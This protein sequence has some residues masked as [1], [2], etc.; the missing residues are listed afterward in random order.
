M[1]SHTEWYPP[2]QVC[3]P[4]ELPPY[5]RDVYVLKPIV[6]LPTDA[7]LI[8]IHDVIQAASKLSAVPGMHDS[9]LYMQ[10][11]DHLFGAQMARYRSRYSL[12]V[13]PSNATYTPPT[14]TLP[15]HICVTLE[16]VCG[17]PSDE[18]IVK[19]QEALRSYEQVS[20]IPTLYDAHVNM[21]LSQH[22]FDLQMGKYMRRA[23]ESPPS[24][25][26]PV[27]ARPENPAA[28]AEQRCQ[29]TEEMA[30]ATNNMGSGANAP[31][32]LVPQ[33]ASDI[34]HEVMERSN[35]ISE[36]LAALLE[37]S[38]ELAEKSTLSTEQAG[39]ITDRFNQVLERLTRL[40][41]STRPATST[42]D[43]HVERFTQLLERIDRMVEL[44]E[45]SAQQT[46]QHA[47]RL[48][49]LVGQLGLPLEQSG[50]LTG[51][52]NQLFE[53]SNQPLPGFNQSSSLQ[54][55]SRLNQLME[56]QNQ[57]L[58]R[59]NELSEQANESAEE[60]NCLTRRSNLL[61]EQVGKPIERLEGVMKNINKVLVGIQH[62]IIRS[63]KGNTKHAVDCLVNDKGETFASSETTYRK[64]FELISG[65]RT[66]RYEHHVMIGGTVQN[67]PFPDDW[68]P[69]FLR[70]H[71]I[72]Q[73]VCETDKS[74]DLIYGK[75]E[76]AR[77]R[78]SRYLS[79]CLG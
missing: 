12:V 51:R 5:L 6:G 19:V 8:G 49:Q 3:Y 2:G 36:R 14:A 61:A 65:N 21:E 20:H 50:Q 48:N 1:V 59:S 75:Q 34:V 42:P 52:L 29:T 22:L 57:H 28:T 35:Q 32:T 56:D 63:S 76:E 27:I 24:S 53:R 46:N 60:F 55:S 58:Q 38:N 45:R 4:P 10:L 67:L 62:A 15:A 54:Q 33:I 40:E 39:P 7:D 77:E 26:S 31:R 16:P 9:S 11:A 66:Q 68:L 74:R 13:F 70:F 43:P 69:E 44:C 64:T 37:R 78:L 47:E 17:A 25:R 73:G 23:G 72:W 71:G 18:Q 41:E 79:S 30:A